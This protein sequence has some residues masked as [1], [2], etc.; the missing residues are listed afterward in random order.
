M[1]K[2]RLNVRYKKLKQILDKSMYYEEYFLHN[3]HTYIKNLVLNIL[4]ICTSLF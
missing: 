2:I 1:Y 3:N 4:D